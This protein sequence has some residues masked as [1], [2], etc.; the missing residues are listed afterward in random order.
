[1]AINPAW[2]QPVGLVLKTMDIAFFPETLALWL[3]P[4]NRPVA[5]GTVKTSHQVWVVAVPRLLPVLSIA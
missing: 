1:M 3:R 2:V 5:L 4:F